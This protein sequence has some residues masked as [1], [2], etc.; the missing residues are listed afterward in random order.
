MLVDGSTFSETLIHT[1]GIGIRHE[2]AE[3]LVL[4][5]LQPVEPVRPPE[6][7]QDYAGRDL[8]D[9]ALRSVVS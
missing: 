8:A 5:V 3:V 6:M 1:F 7:A 9:R 2:N 4:D